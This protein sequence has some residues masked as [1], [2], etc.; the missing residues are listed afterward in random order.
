MSMFTSC[1]FDCKR[2]NVQMIEYLYNSIVSCLVD[3]AC[4]YVPKTRCNFFKFCW[5][6]NL[7]D[8][9]CRSIYA[10]HFRKANV[11]PTSGDIH[12]L[13]RC[14]KAYYKCTLRQKDKDE[15]LSFF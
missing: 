9:K 3:S 7:K 2:G 1:T 11:C 8:L 5:E 10:H 13:K 6:E 15:S 4:N 12:K 14:A